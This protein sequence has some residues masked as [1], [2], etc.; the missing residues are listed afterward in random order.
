[1]LIDDKFDI[2][3]ASKHL[4][5]NM[6][7]RKKD[8]GEGIFYNITNYIFWF[9]SGSVYFMLMNIPLLFIILIFLSL[10]SNPLPTGFEIV[11]VLCCIPIGPASTALLSVMGK[12]V[13][14][15]DIT[16]TRDFFKAYKTNFKQALFL[17]V[18]EISIVVI[19][20][21]DAKTF[22]SLGFPL[23]VTYV[24]YIFVAFIFLI[25]LY[26]FPIQSKFYM[27]S[28]D[29]L[30]LSTY[31]CIKKFN[32]TFLCL[33]VFVVIGIVFTKFPLILIFAPSIIAYTIMHY[34]QKIL[35]EIEKKL[36]IYMPDVSTEDSA[37]VKPETPNSTIS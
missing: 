13:R 8:F 15:K 17:W 18:I 11:F 14:E 4:E 36:K 2:I 3:N 20:V 30:K 22:A 12:L 24:M 25:S 33:S 26:V 27:G 28:K 29:I 16:I 35:G 37:A 34:N 21:V 1:M 23:Y 7:N 5:A 19:L 6:A 9:V 32:I 10:G 31:Y